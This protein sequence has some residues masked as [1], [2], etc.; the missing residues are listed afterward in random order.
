MNVSEFDKTIAAYG[1][2][3]PLAFVY[4][5]T[6]YYFDVDGFDDAKTTV[7]LPVGG[8]PIEGKE[9]NDMLVSA[10]HRYGAERH[11]VWIAKWFTDCVA[12]EL[13]EE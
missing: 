4:D 1:V 12:N 11:K 9:A 6:V 8:E 5:G 7:A 2:I 3:I 10:V 13:S